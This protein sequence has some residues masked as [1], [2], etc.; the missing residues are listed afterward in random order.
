M[1]T[2]TPNLALIKPESVD[3]ADVSKINQNMDRL[4]G[5]RHDGG[6][7]GLAT[8]AVQSGAVSLLS[9]LPHIPGQLFV[10]TDTRQCFFDTGFEWME[11][12]VVSGA[13][14]PT[15]TPTLAPTSTPTPVPPTPTPLGWTTIVSGYGAGY[16][17]SAAGYV[18]FPNTSGWAVPSAYNA[19][20]VTQSSLSPS[21]SWPDAHHVEYWD[22][23]TWISLGEIGWTTSQVT[24]SIP[25]GSANGPVRIAR[26]YTA[27]Q[28]W[29]STV[30][31]EVN[32]I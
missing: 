32:G 24:F 4:D 3:P 25:S 19:V 16:S 14:Q 7:S 13:P 1:A 21:S 23:A 12:Q 22:G 2:T 18:Y 30:K 6:P 29:T 8:V 10:A 31:V 15:A 27:G 9:T 28:T 11:L 17:A 5:H 20:R 26:W